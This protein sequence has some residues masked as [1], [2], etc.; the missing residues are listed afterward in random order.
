M[1]S[2]CQA[3]P[4]THGDGSLCAVLSGAEIEHLSQRSLPLELAHKEV[5]DENVLDQWPI[6]A[7]LNGAIGIQ[8]I[9]DDGR[10]S[11]SAFFTTGDILDLRRSAGRRQVSLRALTDARIC[12]LYPAAFD[13]IQ[14]SNPKARA[15]VTYNLREQA[16]RSVD[17][18]ADLAKKRALEKIASFIFECRNRQTSKACEGVNVAMPMQHCDLAEY[19]GLQPETVSRCLRELDASNIVNLPRPSQ[20]VVK[21]AP[22]LKRLANGAR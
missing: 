22:K 10:R 8:H 21:N 11:I 2:K 15:L 18:A 20:I 12:K 13:G 19:L 4:L 14:E 17:H 1:K 9:L 6:I 16:H 3:C 5:L 7:V